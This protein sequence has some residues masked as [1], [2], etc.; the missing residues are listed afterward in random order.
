[1]IPQR[2]CAVCRTIKPCNELVRVVRT[3]GALVLDTKAKKTQGRGAYI[4]K[5]SACLMSARKRNALERSFSCK[6][7]SLIYDQ[8]EGL[9]NNH[10]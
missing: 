10:E 7:D 1:M 2:M 5:D 6:V 8:L 3:E 9:V 4:C